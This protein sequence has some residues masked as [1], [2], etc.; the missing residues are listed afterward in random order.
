[1]NKL[2]RIGFQL[3]ADQPPQLTTQQSNARESKRLTCR[4]LSQ[5]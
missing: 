3:T 4:I 1:M 2:F 5:M